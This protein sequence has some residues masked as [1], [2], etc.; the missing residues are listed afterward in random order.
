[1][2]ERSIKTE[3]IAEKTLQYL[4]EFNSRLS[5]LYEVEKNEEQKIVVSG[6]HIVLGVELLR[7]YIQLQMG[8]P[9]ILKYNWILIRYVFCIKILIYRSK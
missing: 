2:A 7:L 4:F 1:M 8:N 6:M 3:I 5:P 9:E